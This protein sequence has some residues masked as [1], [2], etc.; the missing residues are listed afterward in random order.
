MN[1]SFTKKKINN[2]F[3][4]GMS[5]DS[6]FAS[7]NTIV[8]PSTKTNILSPQCNGVPSF[9]FSKFIVR[10]K[11][12]RYARQPKHKQIKVNSVMSECAG[13]RA[14]TGTGYFTHFAN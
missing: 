5:A 1:T 10:S 7:K 12:S 4:Y 8:H 3:R 13:Q 14:M 9:I 11:L 6:P 2:E